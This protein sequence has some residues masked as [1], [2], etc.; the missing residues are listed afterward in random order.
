[1]RR[2]EIGPFSVTEASADLAT[3]ELLEPAVALRRLP[4]DA[5]ARGPKDALVRA[6]LA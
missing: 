5:V 4:D 1:L 6:G 2:T 3:V